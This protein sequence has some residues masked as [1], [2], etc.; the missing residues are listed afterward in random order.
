MAGIP[1]KQR[2][3]VFDDETG[4]YVDR[5]ISVRVLGR[6]NSR[7]IRGSKHEEQ[8]QEDTAPSAGEPLP[9]TDQPRPRPR[10]TRGK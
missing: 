3:R 2:V 10:K 6:N 8:P 7:T 4:E 5:E 9:D 1:R